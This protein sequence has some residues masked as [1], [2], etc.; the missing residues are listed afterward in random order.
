MLSAD[1][2]QE[3]ATSGGSRA[4]V[5]AAARAVVSEALGRDDRRYRA[6]RARG[7]VVVENAAQSLAG[8]F[9]RRGVA[10]RAGADT[11]RLSLQAAGY[12]DALEPVPQASPRG[13]ANRVEFRRGGL[14]EWYVNGPLGL[15]Q[16]FTLREPPAARRDGPLTLSLRLRSSLTPQR[17]GD[18]L[19]LLDLSGVRR[20][21]YSGLMAYDAHGRE[22]PASLRV[23][24]GKLTLRVDDDGADYPLTVDPI[25]ATEQ[26]NLGPSDAAASDNFGVAVAL[27][28]ETLVVG[29]YLDDVGPNTNQG[30]AYVFTRSGGTTWSQQAKLVAADGAPSDQFGISVAIYLDTVVVGANF[31]DVASASNRGSAYVFTRSG[32]TWAQQAQLLAS[33]GLASDEFGRAVAVYQDTIAVGAPN[34][35]N[36]STNGA[37]S[38]YVF[39]RSG[40]T[41]AQQSGPLGTADKAASDNFGRSVALYDN[42]IVAGAYLDDAAATDQGSAYVFTRSGTTWTQQSK[43]VASDPAAS[44]NFGVSVGLY[45]NTAIVGAYGE[46]SGAFTSSGAAYVFTRSGTTWT[47]QSKLLASDGATNDFFGASVSIYQDIALVGAYGDDGVGADAGSAYLFSRSGTTWTQ[48]V[49]LLASN[50]TANQQYGFGVAVT[51]VAYAAGAPLAQSSGRVYAGRVSPFADTDGDGVPDAS[52]NCPSVANPGQLNTDGAAD[53]GDACDPDDDNDSVADGSDACA[54][55]DIG[56]TSNAT[57][58][59]DSDGCRDSTEDTDDDNDGKLDATDGCP[60]GDTGWT[61]NASTDHDNDGCRD[62]TEDTDDDNDSV[63]DGSDACSTGDTGWTSNASTDHD[64]D[65]CRDA[66]EDTDDDNDTIADGTDNC[67]TVANASQANSDGD[68]LGDACD[69]DDDNDTIAD[70]TDNCPTVANMDQDDRD[71]DGLG[72]A[73]DPNGAP[74]ADDDS[75]T[76]FGSDTALVI[77][78]G[79]GVLDGDTDPEN[80]TLTV[81]VFV[82]PTHGQLT[83]DPS[84]AFTYQAVEDYVGG[85]SF[86]YTAN[87]G[88]GGTDTATVSITVGAG[89]NGLKA[90][91]TG[92]SAG[93]KINGTANADVIAGLGGND[94]IDGLAGDDT[95]CGGAGKDTIGLG[96]GADYGDGGSGDDTLRGDDG[97]DLIRG[98]IGVDTLSGGE[99]DDTLFGGAGSPDVCKGDNGTDAADASCERT[100]KTETST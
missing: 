30:S 23:R 45:L 53:G 42:T 36:G 54:A 73:C 22:L 56:W 88:F 13:T 1:G 81:S 89:C 2:E 61:S 39:A 19:R 20:L 24:R 83:L 85:D 27:S 25:I 32:T 78:A 12:G 94:M 46:D 93:Q 64:S 62:S 86:T 58:D 21:S 17:K 76:H 68:T 74:L 72:D 26:N 10:V 48:Q 84:G 4:T 69:P 57:T 65:G 79:Q 98:G 8:R 80:D 14:T 77:T 15:Q 41:W 34:D 82:A 96:S 60:R 49:K 92:T 11:F 31:D 51:D 40:T 16:G 9:D 55:G 91:I 97:N 29:S 37:G 70:G 50:S 100:Q 66:G 43:L 52:D 99:G 87:D 59:H 38:I 35:R 44:D 75:Y 63:A 47:Q 3:A 7:G 71:D 90:T 5:P 33:D 18:D 95:L 6:R 67:P 28:G